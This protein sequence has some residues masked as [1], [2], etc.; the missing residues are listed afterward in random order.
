MDTLVNPFKQAS[1]GIVKG[2]TSFPSN[3]AKGVSKLGDGL[4]IVSDS[5]VE[6][7]GKIFRTQPNSN[8]NHSNQMKFDLTRELQTLPMAEDAQVEVR[9]DTVVFP[10]PWRTERYVFDD[11]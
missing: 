6:N 5:V 1:I 10:R 11:V 9:S 4:T 7:A 2:V 3:V 8:G